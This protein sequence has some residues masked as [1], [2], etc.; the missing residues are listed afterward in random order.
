MPMIRKYTTNLR[1]QG[2][3]D[4]IR[5]LLDADKRIRHWSVAVAEPGKPITIDSDSLDQPA[6]SSLF[7][8]AG[9]EIT[10]EIASASPPVATTDATPLASFYPLLLIVSYIVATV[11][12]VE[13]SAGAFSATRAMNH[14]MAG[15][16]LVFSFFKMLDI[17]AFAD[18]F[19]M[20]DIVACR[21]RVF[22]LAYP[23]IELALGVAY[24]ANIQPVATNLVTLIVMSVGF[25]GVA[26]SLVA[27]RKIRCAC[28]GSV[29]NLPMT[30]VTLIED[31]LMA[32]MAATMLFVNH[33]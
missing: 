25:V 11:A 27:K 5:P 21:S 1:C 32:G 2:C 9:Y 29:F 12:V 3:V 20:Y 6:L 8:K 16:F 28:L 30:K 7:K 17:P 26:A 24:L 19:A 23:F 31:G 4:T 14:F 18:S 10:G 33:G 22:A 15:F 13:W